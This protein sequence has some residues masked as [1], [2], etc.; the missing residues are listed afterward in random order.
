MTGE[1]GLP[2]LP[3]TCPWCA[4]VNDD[5]I[6]IHGEHRRPEAGNL[7][8]CW[9]CRRLFWFTGNATER[10]TREELAGLLGRPRILQAVQRAYQLDSPEVAAWVNRMLEL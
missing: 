4:S 2:Q 8:I 9:E 1:N 7:G 3:V 10:L 5:Y 6:E